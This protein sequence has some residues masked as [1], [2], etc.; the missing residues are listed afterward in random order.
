MPRL[1]PLHALLLLC[2]AT[3]GYA[4]ETSDDYYQPVQN[5][6][7]TIPVG[8]LDKNQ[9]QYIVE[10]NFNQ[11]S[12]GKSTILLSSL[13]YGLTYHW[14]VSVLVT[15]LY[16][17]N[18]KGDKSFTNPGD[19]TFNTQ[20]GF[21]N[22]NHS[23][24]SVAVGFN[25]TFPTGSVQKNISNGLNILNP[26]LIIA[27][28]FPKY[29]DAQ[30]SVQIGH[31]FP[32]KIGIADTEVRDT[33]LRPASQ[34]NIALYIPNKEQNFIF[35]AEVGWSNNHLHN[36]LGSHTVYFAPGFI[37]NFGPIFELGLAPAIGLTRS[38]DRYELI[39]FLSATLG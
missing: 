21:T 8:P 24:Y 30:I 33:S 26:Y 31:K 4:F 12:D 23:Q 20:Y 35:S 18:P 25:W 17:N 19:I 10:P 36:E 6:F 38:S 15:P 29:N 27:R 5:L 32:Q 28:D 7:L 13:T 37:W 16:I 39:G 2:A 11:G 1:Q 34:L 9:W 14:D 3:S 22:I